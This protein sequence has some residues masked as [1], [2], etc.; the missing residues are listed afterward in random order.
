M[1]TND[2][3]RGTAQAHPL[4]RPSGMVAL[5]GKETA[6]DDPFTMAT[7]ATQGRW[8]EGVFRDMLR[9]GSFAR[10]VLSCDVPATLA[11]QSGGAQAVARPCRADTF[12]SG[13]LEAIRDGYEIIFRDVFFTYAPK[14]RTP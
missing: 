14:S 13:T 9:E 12:T 10:L 1:S 8:D 6:Y 11:L 2:L 4:T 5:A 3:A 7:L